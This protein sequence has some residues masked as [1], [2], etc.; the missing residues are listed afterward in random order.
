M[1][2]LPGVTL[3][4]LIVDD[5]KI[6]RDRIAAILQNNGTNVVMRQAA[7]VR[8]AVTAIE[9]CEPNVV[10]LDISMPG[11]YSLR[12]GID[13]LRWTK[14]TRPMV[15]VIMLTNLSEEAYRKECARLGAYAF[16]DKTSEFDRLPQ[17]IDTIAGLGSGP[18]WT[19]PSSM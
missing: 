6:M 17:L 1:A 8:S 4:I 11:T 10:I 14:K 16:L 5:A 19:L 12:N 7:D 3:D 2:A 9:S 13:L 18:M 15:N